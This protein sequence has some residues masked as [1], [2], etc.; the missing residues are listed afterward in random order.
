MWGEGAGVTGKEGASSLG[1]KPPGGFL[2]PLAV[3]LGAPGPQLDPGVG[4]GVLPP[5]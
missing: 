2:R 1:A 3:F 5:L 4:E